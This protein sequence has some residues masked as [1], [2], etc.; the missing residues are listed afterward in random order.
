MVHSI[1]PDATLRS[2]PLMPSTKVVFLEVFRIMP[3]RAAPPPASTPAFTANWAACNKAAVL[4]A[5]PLWQYSPDP[6]GR[7]AMIKARAGVGQTRSERLQ[8]CRSNP[9]HA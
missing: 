6:L 7:G 5:A 8:C 2:L 3:G 4:V 1:L 9:L